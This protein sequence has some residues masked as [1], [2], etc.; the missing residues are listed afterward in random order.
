MRAVPKGVANPSDASNIAPAI[1][2]IRRTYAT[3]VV[4]LRALRMDALSAEIDS[5][6]AA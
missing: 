5:K 1:C 6:V 4:E 3:F 2:V